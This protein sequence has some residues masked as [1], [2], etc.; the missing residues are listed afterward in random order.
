MSFFFFYPEVKPLWESQVLYSQLQRHENMYEAKNELRFGEKKK[1]S[2]FILAGF[3]F[4]SM[5][6]GMAGYRI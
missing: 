4:F 5:I 1:S 3:I 2:F 6:A